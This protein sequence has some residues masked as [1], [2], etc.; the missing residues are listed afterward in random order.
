MSTGEHWTLRSIWHYSPGELCRGL[1]NS[2]CPKIL[3]AKESCWKGTPISTSCGHSNLN[4]WLLH[5]HQGN[6]S[7]SFLFFF[8]SVGSTPNVRSN[9][10]PWDQESSAPPTQPASA[11]RETAFQLKNT[12]LLSLWSDLAWN[13]STGIT[14]TENV[15]RYLKRPGKEC[16]WVKHHGVRGGWGA[17][18]PRALSKNERQ[19]RHHPIVLEFPD[20]PIFQGKPEMWIFMW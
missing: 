1:Y 8:L 14:R 2:L 9:S 19:L 6:I 11:P 5:H 4:L 13:S 12:T 3:P 18:G 20:L 7:F 16:H 17:L 10:G 15:Y